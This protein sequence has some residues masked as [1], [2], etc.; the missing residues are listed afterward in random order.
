[1]AHQLDE[2]T[3]S[4]AFYSL[5]Q[6]AWHGLGTVVN[7]PATSDKI[8]EIARL[9]WEIEKIPLF[10]GVESIVGVGDAG[11]LLTGKEYTPV[12]SHVMTRRSDTG[13]MFGVVGANW[14]PIQ[15]RELFTWVNALG[16]WGEMTVETCGALNDGCTVW[17][18]VKMDALRWGL[19]AVDQVQPY[20]LLANGHDG[21]RSLTISPTT[22]RVV[23]A[24]TLRMADTEM[25]GNEAVANGSLSAGWRLIH[26]ADV[27]SR[28]ED[29]REVLIET[30]AAWKATQVEMEKLAAKGF[31][32][33]LLESIVAKVWKGEVEEEDEGEKGKP[34]KVA[35]ERLDKIRGLLHAPTNTTPS[36][37]G[38]LWGGLNAITE[39]LDHDNAIRV[40]EG[41][42][43][44]ELR[45][46]STQFGRA[47]TLKAR[48][49]K[50][51][52]DLAVA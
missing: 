19:D 46:A 49:W 12:A 22:T 21:K 18:L 34:G 42:D 39:F 1:M 47:D 11:D 45:F 43:E 50:S 27:K 23:C 28:M 52:R 26:S 40:P 9:N 36:A 38:T 13:A 30:T 35:V 51:F 17:V 41:K 16:A 7:E 29:A 32:E 33:S 14:T 8:L 4:A 6:S 31:D 2:S 37:K 48:A 20:L 3:G 44:G 24:N 10:A 15:N 5:R 25:R